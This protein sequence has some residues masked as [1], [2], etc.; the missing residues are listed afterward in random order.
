[1]SSLLVDSSP[2]PP[3]PFLLK[4]ASRC[5]WLNPTK[6]STDYELIR[7]YREKVQKNLGQYKKSGTIAIRLICW[8]VTLFQSEKNLNKGGKSSCKIQVVQ[9]QTQ[10]KIQRHKVSRLSWR[11]SRQRKSL[12]PLSS[13]VRVSLRT[14]VKRVSN[15][16]PKV[17]G[18]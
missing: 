17:V 2:P 4:K 11:R 7:G 13:W 8:L 12:S 5:N 9:S 15:A 10:K 18:L 14:H 1:M 3:G 6:I 16:L